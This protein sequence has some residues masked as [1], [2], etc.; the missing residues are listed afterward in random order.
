M[1][2]FSCIGKIIPIHLEIHTISDKVINDVSGASDHNVYRLF[3]VFV[4][5]CLHGVFKIAVVI[6]FITE[7]TD[8][9]LG[10]E[11]ITAPHIL[12]CDDHDLFVPRK[13]QGTEHTCNTCSHDHYVCFNSHCFSPLCPDFSFHPTQTN[14]LYKC[15]LFILPVPASAPAVSSRF[16]VSR[17]LHGPHSPRFSERGELFPEILF[18][19]FC[20]PVQFL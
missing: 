10:Q 17:L 16:H 3:S 5:S 15:V 2:T 18:S 20:R 9:A 6:V 14:L 7:H 13:L 11:R 12:F 4:M 8:P 1:C 19:C